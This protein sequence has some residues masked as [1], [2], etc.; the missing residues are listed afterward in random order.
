MGL[1]HSPRVIKA[2]KI[3]RCGALSIREKSQAR[4]PDKIRRDRHASTKS[5]AQ[6]RG[7][8]RERD[9]N[10]R[11]G[12]PPTHFPGVRL[13][14]LGHLSGSKPFRS[15]RSEGRFDL[16]Q[17][18]AKSCLQPL[19]VR[20]GF[21]R[22]AKNHFRSACA[23]PVCG[24]RM[25]PRRAKVSRA[26]PDQRPVSWR[27]SGAEALRQRH[28]ER[29][30]PATGRVPHRRLRRS[31]EVPERFPMPADAGFRRRRGRA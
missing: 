4:G 3:F 23:S 18:G 17:F 5:A 6:G 30:R 8:R 29:W 16:R 28:P 10:P 19:R 31:S 24:P 12:Y 14:P 15:R 1:F 2:R 7:W 11:D 25:Q 20:T 9:S 22:V 13:R 21:A 27:V 26:G